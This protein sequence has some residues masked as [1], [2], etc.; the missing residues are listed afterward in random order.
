MDKPS[1]EISVRAEAD[2]EN[3]MP[4]LNQI[5]AVS[6]AGGTALQFKKLSGATITGL[7]LSGF[8]T[9]IDIA[10]DTRTDLSGIQ[11]DGEDADVEEAYDADATV[12]AA[13]FDWV[14]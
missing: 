9:N 6:T 13:D 12:D 7:S 4:T 11:I 14:N 3:N 1:I 8:E 2:G 5:T 10:D